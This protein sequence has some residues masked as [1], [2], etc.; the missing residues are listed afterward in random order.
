VLARP[1]VNRREVR[2]R[3]AQLG[4]E[5]VGGGHPEFMQIIPQAAW[6]A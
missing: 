3:K 5:R 6:P 4:E 2:L 1:L